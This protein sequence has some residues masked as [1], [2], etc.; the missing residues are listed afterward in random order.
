MLPFGVCMTM[1]MEP[2]DKNYQQQSDEAVPLS[3]TP[4]TKGLSP[5]QSVDETTTPG[6]L[7]LS[8]KDLIAPPYS[9]AHLGKAG[10]MEEGPISGFGKEYVAWATEVLFGGPNVGA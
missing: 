2:V 3:T 9:G 10:V 4:C 5:P 1:V 7:C 8:S 6:P